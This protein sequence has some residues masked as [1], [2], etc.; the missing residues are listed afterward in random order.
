M[1]AQQQVQCMR[2]CACMHAGAACNEEDNV[3][4]AKGSKP[5]VQLCY[6]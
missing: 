3:G 4:L 2:L 5:R 6:W 1:E